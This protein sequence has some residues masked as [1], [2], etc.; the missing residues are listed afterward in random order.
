MGCSAGSAAVWLAANQGRFPR[1]RGKGSTGATER[2]IRHA[3]APC[4]ALHGTTRGFPYARCSAKK[5]I[6]YFVLASQRNDLLFG[7]HTALLKSA[8]PGMCGGW[9]CSQGQRH[10]LLLGDG[11]DHLGT[12]EVVLHWKAATEAHLRSRTFQSGHGFDSE[13]IKSPDLVESV[14]PAYSRT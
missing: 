3:W 1:V 12:E 2:V 6:I 4:L 9:S 7:D 8:H 10:P 14:I 13:G 5:P 11:S